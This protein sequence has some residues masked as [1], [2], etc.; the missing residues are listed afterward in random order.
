[1]KPSDKTK[2]V[3]VGLALEAGDISK[4]DLSI[5][6]IARARRELEEY[7]RWEMI[8]PG[9]LAGFPKTEKINCRCTPYVEHKIIIT[10]QIQTARGALKGISFT[11]G[12]DGA[13]GL[14]KLIPGMNDIIS[15]ACNIDTRG[16]L[17]N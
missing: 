12:M 16:E 3:E 1:M 17:S 9:D 10:A 11:R 8:G 15:R 7:R 2:W 5:S 4:D 6:E 14:A 13:K